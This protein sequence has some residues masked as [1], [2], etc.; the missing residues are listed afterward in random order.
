MSYPISTSIA[1]MKNLFVGYS[2]KKKRC[3]NFRISL[4]FWQNHQ[5]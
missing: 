5:K 1:T 3:N 4:L 2:I